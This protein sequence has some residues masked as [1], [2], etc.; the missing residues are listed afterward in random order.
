[1]GFDES[2]VDHHVIILGVFE[3]PGKDRFPDPVLGPTTKAFVGT[4][5]IAV[6]LGQ[7]MPVG[8]TAQHPH[9]AIDKAVIVYRR[10]A[11]ITDLAGQMITDGFKLR[12][13]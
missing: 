7:I 12:F 9:H 13:G 5:P 3:Q 11:G 2:R 4:F 8:A 10:A 1:M 6:T